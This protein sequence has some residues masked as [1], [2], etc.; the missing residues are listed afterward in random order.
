MTAAIFRT[1]YVHGELVFFEPVNVWK[2]EVSYEDY[3]GEKTIERSHVFSWGTQK[4][5]KMS[6][7]W[8]VPVDSNIWLPI[9]NNQETV[10]TLWVEA[11][12]LGD[13]IG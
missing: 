3:V 7:V 4:Y 5:N 9:H 11:Q 6:F 12:T 2:I 8:W 1:S 10:L 13:T